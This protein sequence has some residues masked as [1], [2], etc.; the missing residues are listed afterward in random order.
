MKKT[1][2]ISVIIAIAICLLFFCTNVFKVRKEIITGGLDKRISTATATTTLIWL[3]PTQDSTSTDEY[4]LTTEL[5]FATQEMD[6]FDMNLIQTASTSAELAWTYWFSDDNE[7]WY[8][9]GGATDTND[10]VMTHGATKYVHK[11]ATGLTTTEYKNTHYPTTAGDILRADFTKVIFTTN[12]A[13]TSMYA[14][15]LK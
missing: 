3:E 12:T 11:W 9:E 1:I 8:P 10:L 6:G 4:I 14:E 5:K 2:F 15:I 13:S 7:T